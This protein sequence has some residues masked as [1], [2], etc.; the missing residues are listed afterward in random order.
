MEGFRQLPQVDRLI[1]ALGTNEGA[2]EPHALKAAAARRVIDEARV[3][4]GEGAPAPSREQLAASATRL[5]EAGRRRRLVP[6]VNATGV[7][8]HTNLGRAPMGRRQLDAVEAVATGYSNLEFDLA[9]GRRGSRYDHARELL[10]TLTGAEAALVVNNNAAAVLLVLASVARGREVVISRGELI[11]IGG[12]FRIPA[13]LQESGATLREVGTT[14]RTHL[15]DYREA[16]GESTAAVM[17]VH[18]SNYQVVGF[19]KSVTGRELAELAHAAPGGGVPLIHDIGSGL[20][21]HG[22]G[23]RQL[24]WLADEP[25]VEASLA[26]GA[27]VVTFSGDKLLG[28]PQAGLIVGRAGIIAAM[29]HSPLLRTY[30]VDKTTLAALEATLLAYLEGREE[31]LPLWSMALLAPNEIETRAAAVRSL[32]LSQ[33]S[34]G[35]DVDAKVELV[36]GFST[37]GGGSAP[38]SRIPTVLLEIAPRTRAVAAVRADLIGGDPPVVARLEEDRLVLDLRTVAPE[39]DATVAEALR[40]VLS[41]DTAG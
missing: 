9:E 6:V 35:G 36:D 29:E 33:P 3:A 38:T 13:I 8:L 23:G 10:T 25:T 39:Q 2:A 27:D 17:K 15:R 31:E 7:L 24:P 12:E 5:L 18:P 11:E 21:R 30:R 1:D 26:D 28:G 34:Q 40:R 4:I 20:L 19:T 22:I 14:N 37:T 41:T 32:L 16:I